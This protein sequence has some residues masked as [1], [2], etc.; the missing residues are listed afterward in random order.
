MAGEVVL[1]KLV[2]VAGEHVAPPAPVQVRVTDWLN[3]LRA[4]KVTAS[5]IC[6]PAATA[7]DDV[8][9]VRVKVGFVLPCRGPVPCPVPVN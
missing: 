9:G 7:I 6:A 5:G 4:V 2:F 8:V 1:T 3:P